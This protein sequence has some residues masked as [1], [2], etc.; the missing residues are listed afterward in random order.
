METIRLLGKLTQA[1]VI[2]FAVVF[3]IA[4]YSLL[5]QVIGFPYASLAMV[6]FLLVLVAM[7]MYDKVKGELAVVKE[8]ESFTEVSKVEC[9][10]AFQADVVVLAEEFIPKP[11][12][13]AEEVKED[14]KGLLAEAI[15]TPT[16]LTQPSTGTGKEIKRL[17]FTLIEDY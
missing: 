2:T 4:C 10:T 5:S 17:N 15:S 13:E 8:V 14:V 7:M 9:E 1:Y 3:H 11:I 12:N 6:V 16:P